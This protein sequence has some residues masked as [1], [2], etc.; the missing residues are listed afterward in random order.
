MVYLIRNSKAQR[1]DLDDVAV[2]SEPA[3]SVTRYSRS[4]KYGPSKSGRERRPEPHLT[5]FR[6]ARHQS[7]PEG[8][9]ARLS[10]KSSRQSSKEGHHE[11]GE[12]RPERKESRLAHQGSG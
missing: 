12:R 1:D 6:E 4:R 11:R 10:R 8:K 5:H 3:P 7:R 2:E 9:E